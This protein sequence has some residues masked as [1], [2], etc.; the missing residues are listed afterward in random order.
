VEEIA[1]IARNLNLGEKEFR[2]RHVRRVGR[3]LTL[4]ENP[5]TNDCIFLKSGK[6][7][8]YDVRPTQCR[9]WP[10]WASNLG[11]PEDWILAGMRC[12]GVNRGSLHGP[13]EI[14]E[15]LKETRE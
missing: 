10:F 7:K 6:C 1:A 14:R 5:Q 11:S 15:K 3:R 2:Q 9:T 4:I 8:I 12:S 13:E